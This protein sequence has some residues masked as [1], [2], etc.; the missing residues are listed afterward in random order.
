MLVGARQ[1]GKTY[2]LRK[3]CSENF[4]NYIYI[5]LD[6]EKSIRR[7]FEETIKP[8]EIISL[9]SLKLDIKINP[10]NTIIFLDEIQ[11]CEE[12]IV[13]LKYFNEAN[14]PYKI[15]C[16]GSLLG[17]ALN[18]FKSSF[19]VGK[20]WF[21][22]LNSMDFEEFLWATNHNILL[23]EIKKHFDNNIQ[24]STPIHDKA[25]RL[26]KDYLYIGGMPASVLE[27]INSNGDLMK[28]DKKVKQ[29]ILTS[30]I[31]DMSKYT[32]SS[33]NIKIN[34]MYRSIPKQLNRENNK[35]T[36]KLIGDDV[37]KRTYETSI[38]WL[39]HAN[40]V[41]KCILLEVPQMPLVVYAKENVF[42]I[43]LNDVGLLCELAELTPKDILTEN[44]KFFNGMLTENYI[45]QTFIS[46]NLNLNYWKSKKNAEVDFLL[47]ID[48]E[49][50]PVEVKAA[51]N[52]KAQSLRV[53]IER[54]K[55][56]YSIKISAKNFGFVNNI[57][58]I[59]LYAAYLLKDN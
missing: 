29:D 56:K 1:V 8:H 32:T 18:R 15:V 7:I 39:V 44:F 41:N 4:P 23:N 52:T 12:A 20:V 31:F 37:N 48:G 45:A 6:T 25:L 33:E 27:Y 19:P 58:S 26:Y 55:P 16:A 34:K 35:F 9:I 2:I 13:S 21:E 53:Y 38:D 49:I 57:K 50:I 40:L 47:H 28:Y 22:T 24:I 14:E 42:K 5:N 11:V 54:Y 51:T 17:V 3:F 43:Y 30:Y 46:N 59:P 10:E 36:Y